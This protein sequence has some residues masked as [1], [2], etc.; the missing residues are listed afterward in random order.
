MCTNYKYCVE[1]RISKMLNSLLVNYKVEAW[2]TL[3]HLFKVKNINDHTLHFVA[4]LA[5]RLDLERFKQAV[6]LSADAFPLIRSN[7]N[8]TKNKSYWEDKEYTIDDIVKILETSNTDKNVNEFI[9]REI[10]ALN[11]PQ[12]KI[13]IIRDDKND[14]LCVLIPCTLR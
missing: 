12:L 9:C 1:G 3:Q 4:T 8:E 13:E 7:F 10:D 14:T 5:E 11:G 6:N 2:D